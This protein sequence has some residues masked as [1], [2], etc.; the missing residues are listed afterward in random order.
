MGERRSYYI[1]TL[2]F[3]YTLAACSS[4]MSSPLGSRL[5]ICAMDSSLTRPTDNQA[6]SNNVFGKL[7]H[8]Q[9]PLSTTC[10]EG[11]P[12]KPKK[13]DDPS[14]WRP[15]Q[16][17][18]GRPRP[19]SDDDDDNDAPRRTPGQGAAGRWAANGARWRPAARPR[20]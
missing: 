3:L 9:R 15:R 8:A 20:G 1:H 18:P 5:F 14:L 16:C 19:T 4:I 11:G 2:A 10:Q 12:Q 17:P 7:R 13:L 6:H